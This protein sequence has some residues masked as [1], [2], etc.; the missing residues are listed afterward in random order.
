MIKSALKRVKHY[1]TNT[2]WILTE[3]ILSMAAGF[4]LAV[5]LA[6]YLG[7]EQ[8][9]IF[10]YG[11]AMVTL[12]AVVGHVGMDGLVVRELISSQRPT[13]ET[14]GTTFGMKALGYIIAFLGVVV[15]FI[16]T[17][18][19]GSLEFWVLNTLALTIIFRPFAIIDF[20]FQSQLQAK[21]SAYVRLSALFFSI[22]LKIIFILS[23]ASLLYFAVAN[24]LQA[25]LA[26]V[27]FI[28]IYHF[29]SNV[30]IKNWFFSGERA[31]S[32]LKEGSLVFLGS[33]FAVIY[34]KIDQ[35]MLRWLAGAEEVGVY[36][37]AASLSEAWYFI[38]IAIVSS[39][40]PRLINLRKTNEELF[41]KR[42]QQLF[43]ILFM[44]AIGVALLVTVVAG[45]LINLL[46]GSEY[47]EASSIL[48][49][50]IWAA[51]FIF[52]RAALSK[53]ILIEKVYVF[54]LVSQ[55]T[56]AVLNV[57]LNFLLIPLW[58]GVGAAYATLFS[59]MAASY[60]ALVIYPRSRPIF[61]MMTRAIIS[62]ARYLPKLVRLPK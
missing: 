5:L 18:E 23:G 44:L 16:G 57:A 49:I 56:G 46:F 38:P 31:R 25:L 43:D 37:V 22:L 9:G 26:A 41:R 21:Y 51:L 61:W 48:V 34:L 12:F 2:S 39:F 24:V 54:S 11:L 45:P 33:I 14:L 15:F 13:S 47:N 42:L 40:F 32:L 60:L 20:W 29:K 27:F 36:A 55:G 50:H 58:G 6:R 19:L 59:Y 53:W 62:P 17:E 1:L 52:M 35:V 3:K 4:F 10:S 28:L 8:Y 7:P 30:R